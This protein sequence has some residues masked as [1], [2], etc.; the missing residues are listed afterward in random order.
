MGSFFS[1]PG[2]IGGIDN[3]PSVM[4]LITHGRIPKAY[5]RMVSAFYFYIIKTIID[6]P[7]YKKITPEWLRTLTEAILGVDNVFF[8]DPT[9]TTDAAILS[10]MNDSKAKDIVTICL[11]EEISK[12][13][14]ST[15]RSVRDFTSV[16]VSACL[17][18]NV[19][20]MLSAQ[21]SERI[22]NPVALVKGSSLHCSTIGYN[23]RTWIG[24]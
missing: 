7:D 14:I 1:R 21:R 9:T 13:R 6:E 16:K 12:S 3:S 2:N 18:L 5:E 22:T 19:H 17:L 20:A 10:A 11:R 23:Q 15:N 8:A 4:H 24:T